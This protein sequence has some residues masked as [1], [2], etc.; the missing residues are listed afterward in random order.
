MSRYYNIQISDNNGNLVTPPGFDPSILGG[1]SYT[2]W[3]NGVPLT[4]A[5]DVELDLPSGAFAQ[6]QEGGGYI[7]I[8]GISLQEIAQAKNLDNFNIKV[9]GGMKPGLPLATAAAS[10]AGLLIQG[11][12]Q[13]AFGNWI[14]TDQTLDF[15]I[16]PNAGNTNGTGSPG[17]PVNLVLNWP[18]GTPLATALA[19]T[20]KQ[21]F[22][23]ASP[24]PTIN[25]SANLIAP[26]RTST[27]ST[28][29]ISPNLR[30]SCAMPRVTS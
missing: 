11:Q 4:S 21:A 3:A 30:P 28:A 29:A 24:A 19:N 17:Q 10:Q 23:N 2:S 27:A 8:W 15:I 13:Q 7:R 20:L 25:I 1:A 5:W 16:V 26:A 18:K 14:D 22:P 9:Y 12:I 6:P